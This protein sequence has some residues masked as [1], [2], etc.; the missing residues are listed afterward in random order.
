MPVLIRLVQ[1]VRKKGK[2]RQG[3]NK[4]TDVDPSS[5]V[6][7]LEANHVKQHLLD[8][9]SVEAWSRITQVVGTSR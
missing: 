3:V 6:P 1:S 5:R 9:F 8:S 2:G 7:P 4:A